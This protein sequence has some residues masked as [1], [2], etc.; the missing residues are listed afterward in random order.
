MENIKFN[1]TVNAFLRT[2]EINTIYEGTD[3][4]IELQFTELDEWSNFSVDN[5]SFDMHF[6]Y[7]EKIWINVYEVFDNVIDY[8]AIQETEVKI[9]IQSELINP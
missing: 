7:E 5:R 8:T 4:K 2:V 1:I 6:H 9:I 3:Y